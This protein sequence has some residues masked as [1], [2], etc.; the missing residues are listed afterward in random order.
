[1][2]NRRIS[3][4]VKVAAIN[5]YNRNLL[6]L[7][8]ILDC[9]EFSQ[10][11]FFRSLRLW[12][13]TGSVTK[14]SSLLRGRPRVLASEDLQYILQLVRARPD[15]FLDE[16]LGLL[17]RNRFISVHF[18]TIHDE[19]SHCGVSRKLLKRLA[20]ERNAAFRA[21]FVYQMS[22]YSAD[23]LGFIDETSKND[24][25]VQRRFGRSQKNSRASK[26]LNFVRGRRLS[27]CGLLTIDGMIT[28]YVREGSLKRVDFLEFLEYYVVSSS[29]TIQYLYY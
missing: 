15:W 6:E 17:N 27:A 28:S 21:D 20:T 10:S 16:L 13:E 22:F 26:K 7:E 2:V 24:R 18:K 11:T 8:D 1:M 23:Q 12:R 5:L 14:P 4:D 29:E 9:C 3:S 25:T 19:L